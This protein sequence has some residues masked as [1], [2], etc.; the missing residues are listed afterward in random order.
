MRALLLLTV[1]GITGCIKPGSFE[2]ASNTECM[3][4][5]EQ[6]ACE[7]VGRCSFSDPSCSSGRRFGD[8]SGTY[9]NQCV[10]EQGTDAGP[11]DAPDDPDAPPGTDA[12][13]DAPPVSGCPVGYAP[14]PALSS[15]HQYRKLLTT[16]G[17][18][19]HRA[20]CGGEPGNVYLAIPDDTLEIQAL[21][22]LAGTDFWV[23]ISDA[24]TEGIYMDVKGIPATFL[25]WAAAEPDNAGNQD[26]VR[27]LSP[28]GTIETL[29]C[30]ITAIA[31]C[32][33]EP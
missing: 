3:R 32:E 4:D 8:L 23:G 19:N 12:M 25:P 29:N 26:C 5:G 14:L 20:A 30:G 33:C 13:I 28:S 27:A 15:T 7:S 6:G 21:V 2:C 11:I 18:T 31:I 24:A 1:V 9:A 10:G 22:T 17:W 16:A